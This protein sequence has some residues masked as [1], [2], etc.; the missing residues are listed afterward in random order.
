MASVI[1]KYVKRV[2]PNVRKVFCVGMQ[3]MRECLEAEGIEVLGA[4]REVTRS[5]DDSEIQFSS[6]T[7]EGYELDPEVGAVVYG[8][9]FGFN[10][11]KLCLAT[12]YLNELKVPLIA[13]NDD[14]AAL[15]K[16][17]YM[18]GAGAVLQSILATTGLKKGSC[19]STTS[20]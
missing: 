20:L 3:S 18:P 16:G 4:D 12:L 5:G 1:A 11:T 2:Y 10:H 7:Y 6:E 14:A 15:I 9:D 13:T 8:I 19:P 17:K